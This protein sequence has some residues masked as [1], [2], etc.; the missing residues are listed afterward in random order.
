MALVVP[1]AERKML[2]GGER[3]WKVE[4][5]LEVSGSMRG[6]RFVDGDDVEMSRR[7]MAWTVGLEERDVRV[8]RIWEPYD[9]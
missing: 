2:G 1:R 6:W 4:G 9:V 7:A 3:N 8:V 5:H